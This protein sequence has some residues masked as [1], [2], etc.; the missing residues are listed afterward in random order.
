MT[1]DRHPR[2]ERH[3]ALVLSAQH[4]SATHRLPPMA[5]PR[6]LPPDRVSPAER[7]ALAA[8][9]L[10]GLLGSACTPGPWF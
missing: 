3:A 9:L 4:R 10:A 6:R 8:A 2:T 5:H 7:L 1:A